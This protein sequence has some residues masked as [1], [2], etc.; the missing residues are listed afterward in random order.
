MM[1]VL[2]IQQAIWQ[3]ATSCEKRVTFDLNM[4]DFESVINTN[5][6]FAA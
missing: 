5:S 2:P 4:Q 1:F 6:D 3:K